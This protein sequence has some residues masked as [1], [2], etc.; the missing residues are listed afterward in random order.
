MIK[1]F[2]LVYMFFSRKF[3]EDFLHLFRREPR[4]QGRT[5]VTDRTIAHIE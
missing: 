5:G 3:R 1:Y 4:A 2:Y